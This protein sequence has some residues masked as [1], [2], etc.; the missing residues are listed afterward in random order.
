MTKI[1]TDVLF[2]SSYLKLSKRT[3][4]FRNSTSVKELFKIRDKCKCVNIFGPQSKKYYCPL[5]YEIFPT[6]EYRFSSNIIIQQKKVFFP[7]KFIIVAKIIFAIIYAFSDD[8]T[9]VR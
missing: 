6:Q 8:N 1:K 4:K 2:N 5:G 9:E 7:L 3:S